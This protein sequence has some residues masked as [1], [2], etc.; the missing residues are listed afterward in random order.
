MF[1]NKISDQEKINFVKNLNIMLKSGISIDEALASL[2]PQTQ[3]KKFRKIINVLKSDAEKGVSLSNS[4]TKVKKDFGDVFIS[5]VRTGDASGTLEE[6]LNFLADWLERNENLKKEINAALL[7]SKIILSAT[8]LLGG[9]LT[10]FVLP[11]LIPLF[12]S[13]NVKLPLVTRIL[14]KIALF[15]QNDWY[16]VI[17]G[18][19]SFIILIMLLNKLLLTRQLFHLFYIRMPMFGTLVSDYQLTLISQIFYTLLKSGISI[20]EALKITS[21]GATNIHYK[22]SLEK[23]MNRIIQ[24]VSFEEALKDYPKLYPQTFINIVSVGEKSGTLENSFS[25]L[26]EFYSKEVNNKTKKL[27]ILI[28]P[29]L[30]LFIGL[31][32]G[33]VAI[34][35]I[36]PIYEITSGL[37]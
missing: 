7:Y 37:K 34:A 17:F 19:I 14:F 9:G 32:V 28:E 16:F 13:L 22:K 25:Y 5:L 21:E 36:S 23:I 35:I 26:S 4:I 18:I 24:G 33:F 8:F 2:G 12:T 6:N 15:I 20:D 29:L 31:T 3:S 11:R 30:L 27:P 1:L 10:V